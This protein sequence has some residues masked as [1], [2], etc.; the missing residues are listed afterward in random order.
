LQQSDT[1]LAK[2]FSVVEVKTVVECLHGV[3]PDL[4]QH[5]FVICQ[6]LLT[7]L[8]IKKQTRNW[9][10]FCTEYNQKKIASNESSPNKNLR[11]SGR[12]NLGKSLKYSKEF[13]V[14]SNKVNNKPKAASEK[15][16]AKVKHKVEAAVEKAVANLSDQI[17][18]N[19]EAFNHELES[20]SGENI[21]NDNCKKDKKVSDIDRTKPNNNFKIVTKRE[22]DAI[23]SK[24]MDQ[25][26]KNP[27]EYSCKICEYKSDSTFALKKHIMLHLNI[28][29]F[30]CPM[31]DF[32]I[33]QQNNFE[34]HLNTHNL[35]MDKKKMN[36]FQIVDDKKH[37]VCGEL[38]AILTKEVPTQE[39]K[40]KE[41]QVSSKNSDV[42][43][44]TNL[45][46]SKI[47]DVSYY[48]RLLDLSY[49]C[50]TCSMV[51]STAKLMKRHISEEHNQFLPFGCDY[52]TE[53]FTSEGYLKIHTA[54]HKNKKKIIA[55]EKTQ[56]ESNNDTPN[57]I[58]VGIVCPPQEAIA[59]VEPFI[60]IEQLEPVQFGCKECEFQSNS[61]SS[62][63]QHLYQ[64]FNIYI[65]K[66]PSC[67]HLNRNDKS[68]EIH[69]NSHGLTSLAENVSSEL[70]LVE[71]TQIKTDAYKVTESLHNLKSDTFIREE[72]ART[73]VQT[74]Y[75]KEKHNQDNSVDGILFKCKLCDF[76]DTEYVTH[77]HV[78]E[79]HLKIFQFKCSHCGRKIKSDRL[80][81]E[82]MEKDHKIDN[83]IYERC[84]YTEEEFEVEYV[85]LGVGTEVD[86]ADT[87]QST[88]IAVNVN[89]NN[90]SLYEEDTISEMENI[91]TI[92]NPP[93]REVEGNVEYDRIFDNGVLN[94]AMEESDINTYHEGVLE[95]QLMTEQSLGD[96]MILK[97]RD[98]MWKTEAP[99][100]PVKNVLANPD[101]SS[102]NVMES[103]SK[104]VY[105]SDAS[106]P[107]LSAG[108]KKLQK[109]LTGQI[110]SL[111]E[112]DRLLTCNLIKNN[113]SKEYECTI[114]EGLYKTK[115]KSAARTHIFEHFN[116]YLFQCEKCKDMF[117]LRSTYK[118]HL[119]AHT[120]M[121]N[122]TAKLV[123]S[124]NDEIIGGYH[125][126]REYI[127]I[128]S[129]KAGPIIDSY[130]RFNEEK[131]GYS[132]K[133]CKHRKPIK[134]SMREHLLRQHLKIHRYMCELCGQAFS[135]KSQIQ[136][137]MSKNHN[138]DFKEEDNFLKTGNSSIVERE[139]YNSKQTDFDVSDILKVPLEQLKGCKISTE[140]GKVV[141]KA[142]VM[143]NSEENVYECE[144]CDYKRPNASQIRNHVLSFH[145][146]V[147]MYKCPV[148]DCQIKLR[149]WG[150]YT[151][152][153]KVHEGPRR[154]APAH[155][156]FTID[157]EYHLLKE[158]VFL[159]KNEGHK[160][161]RTY[162]Y[163]DENT[164]EYKCKLCKVKGK[165]Q[166][167]E[168]HVL[169]N[170]LPMVYL[171]MCEYCGKQFRY[172]EGRYKDH[173]EEH[174]AGKYSCQ[175]CSESG[176]S[177]IQEKLF[178]KASLQAHIRRIH[179]KGEFR[180]QVDLCE[181]VTSTLALMR[182]HERELHAIGL[183]RQNYQCPLC[184][185]IFPTKTRCEKH[186]RSCQQGQSRIGFRKQYLDS[187]EWLGKGVY[188][189]KICNLEL[190]KDSGLK[191]S[192]TRARNHLVVDHGMKEVR[193]AK[194]NWANKKKTEDD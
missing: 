16:V 102:Q 147:F 151:T 11:K 86:V 15:H 18:I 82:H 132:C 107:L 31:C 183:Q 27:V 55:N 163:L 76:R 158:P 131:G 12:S 33:N 4:K 52:C 88:N 42:A 189:C 23:C 185:H 89:L 190:Q 22:S 184:N 122:K 96:V 142:H 152:H 58:G 94:K 70:S 30:Q 66:C 105:I 181:T 80:L 26:S 133:L 157:Q 192:L 193:R 91:P 67:T 29:L 139:E 191:N 49:S 69:L 83:F 8:G 161:A 104:K 20:E 45:Q 44:N 50:N 159:G 111:A 62:L 37:K 123:A 174:T 57:S 116:V 38:S 112:A 114:C 24:H 63:R 72:K 127:F 61:R 173:V 180:C 120:K 34:K 43:L 148:P 25:L 126:L 125:L 164:Q 177:G 137:H 175:Q 90:E 48:R 146:D 154:K 108:K 182:Q 179:R 3:K 5:G 130:I 10:N 136:V 78:V 51:C 138:E 19:L 79:E 118:V 109:V 167:V 97:G 141:M 178:T 144:L 155:Q 113:S 39:T 169:A 41:I 124:G 87:S 71:Q 186:Q 99:S 75:I 106:S 140:Q 160:A 65:Y 47:S 53:T 81:K 1:I 117:R 129:G 56:I 115:H 187:L 156:T 119:R 60:A 166:R 110:C 134:S 153:E 32:K 135:F 93:I 2:Q 64:H 7:A 95:D 46:I 143:K 103:K 188:R 68:F 14:S 170:H 13:I 100:T 168:L 21:L 128:P 40:N 73:L 145:Y 150:R 59:L 176:E 9:L 28:C 98:P 35:T 162:F 121:E 194:M 54:R 101:L 84:V 77:N 165:H 171:F 149:N 74:Y 36:H 172:S 6:D 17:T 85:G 92:S